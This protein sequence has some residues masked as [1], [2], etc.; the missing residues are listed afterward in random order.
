MVVVVVGFDVVSVTNCG[1]GLDVMVVVIV[2]FGVVSVTNC[3]VG[4]G[5]VVVLVSKVVVELAFVVSL[6]AVVV[7]VVMFVETVV[8]I[9]V[10]SFISDSVV[11]GL[12]SQV[13]SSGKTQVLF[14]LC[15]SSPLKQGII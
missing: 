2:G 3:G 6:V 14:S 8:V 13:E 15:H 5:F 12:E 10:S 9:K 7:N 1:V 11:T 4:L